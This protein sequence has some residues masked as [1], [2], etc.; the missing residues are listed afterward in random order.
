MEIILLGIYSYLRLADFLQVQMAAVEHRQPGH[1]HHDPDRRP[2]AADPG[3]EHRRAVVAGRARDQLRGRRSTR[4]S[5]GMVTEVPIEPNRPIKRATSCS[6]SIRALRDSRSGIRGASSTS[7]ERSCS[8]PRPAPPISGTVAGC[9][10]AERKRCSPTAAGPEREN[11]TRNSPSHGAGSQFDYEQAAGQRAEPRRA[12][13]TRPWRAK[14]QAK[15]KL[16]AKNSEGRAGRSRQRQGADRAGRSATRAKPNGDLKPDHLRA[17]QRHGGRP[18]AAS[19]RHGRPA[20]DDARHELRRGRA[21]DHGHLSIRTKCARSSRARKPRSPSRCIPAGSS[22][23]KWTPS[24]GPR[25]RAS[26]PSAP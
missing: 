11:Q 7:S 13:W 3:A 22:S 15:D 9:D 2:D 18:D 14:A 8:R 1:R 12:S 17:R 26:C 20:A 10:R 23:A 19:G 24:C 5:S 21:V 4:A 6:S 25:R 16:S